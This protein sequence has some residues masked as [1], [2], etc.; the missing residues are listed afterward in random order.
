MYLLALGILHASR[1]SIKGYDLIDYIVQVIYVFITV[2][3]GE[4]VPP[5]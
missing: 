2:L 5:K 1:C 3:S 4:F